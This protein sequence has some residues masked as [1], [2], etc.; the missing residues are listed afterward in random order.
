MADMPTKSSNLMQWMRQSPEG[1]RQQVDAALEYALEATLGE[2]PVKP[3]QLVAAKLREWDAAVNGDWPLRREAEA[4]F[5]RA[6]ADGSGH[7]DLTELTAM[8]EDPKFAELVRCTRRH[9]SGK[10]PLSEPA[11]AYVLHSRRRSPHIASNLEMQMLNNLDIDLSGK[12]SLAEWL[13]AMK[14]NVEKSE[15]STR[16]M[17]Q[18]YDDYLTGKKATR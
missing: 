7:L 2:R 12:V 18:L 10:P 11:L 4:V 16:A 5:G 14:A 9:P 1:K 17:L 15:E 3:L 13:L 8:R 6:D